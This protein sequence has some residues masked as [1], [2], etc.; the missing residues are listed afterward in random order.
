MWAAPRSY[1]A[2]MSIHLGD[3]PTWIAALGGTGAAAAA[4][5]QLALQRRQLANQQQVIEAETERNRKRDELVD[6]Q[7]RDFDQRTQAWERRQAEKITVE[8]TPSTT[9]PRGV[10]LNEGDRVFAALVVNNSDRPIRDVT[11]AI[12][13]GQAEAQPPSAYHRLIPSTY[14]STGGFGISETIQDSHIGLMMI[15]DRTEF[16]FPYSTSTRA[17]VVLVRFTDDAGLR[18]Q[19]DPNL[20][21]ER[22]P[23]QHLTRPSEIA[24]RDQLTDNW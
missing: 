24:A 12:V 22:V 23:S 9:P 19:V 2:A 16:V 8:F 1:D 5:R 7:L 11:A 4:L 18:W 15:D 6:R 20:H 14:P 3:L 17:A 10:T 21:L 13:I